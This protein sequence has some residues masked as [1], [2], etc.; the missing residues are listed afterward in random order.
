MTVRPRG[1]A[2]LRRLTTRLRELRV[3][4]GLKQAQ[5]ASQ[6]EWSQPKVARIERGEVPVSRTDLVAL[7]SLYGVND[8]TTM[9]EMIEGARAGRHRHFSK[10]R[11]VFAKEF[12][13]YL[14]FEG[15]AQ[16]IKHFESD[17]LPGPL[18]TADYARAV[19]RSAR[20]V[21]GLPPSEREETNAIIEQKVQARMDRKAMLL[22]DSR[23]TR[24]EF[25]V[26]EGVLRRA[27]GAESG[28]EYL[29]PE[30]IDHLH[31]LARKPHL[32]VRI[33]PF[34]A[35]AHPGMSGGFVIL[36]L[37]DPYK[38]SLL[39]IENSAG[40]LSTRDQPERVRRF[41]NIFDVLRRRSVYLGDFHL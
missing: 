33:L 10:Y 39:Y 23:S 12:L 30:Q 35:G 19:L 34:S 21:D 3:S 26:S 15:L 18:Q 5:V 14:E 41:M 24:A 38:D 17:V 27:V 1:A 22:Q 8:E 7:L 37:P 2:E 29:M 31:E 40:E 6:L 9:A 32:D 36:E 25:I 4:A 11:G 20:M 28:G 13:Y 16:R